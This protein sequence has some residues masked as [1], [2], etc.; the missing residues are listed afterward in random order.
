M[1]FKR[2]RPEDFEMTDADRRNAEIVG[3]G[4]AGKRALGSTIGTVAGGALGALGFLGGPAL[5]GATMGLGASLGG[6]AGDAIGGAA[7]E[8]E[9]SD[10]EEELS[11]ADEE[12]KRKLAMYQLRQ[13][14]LDSLLS[15]R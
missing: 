13:G 9:L 10:A 5:G 3:E 4:G 8:G 7:A 14:A 6:A 2:Y 11:E 12:R 1:A 15:E